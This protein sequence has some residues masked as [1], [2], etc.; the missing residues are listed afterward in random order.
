RQRAEPRGRPGPARPPAL[1]ARAGAAGAR[2][3]L[4]LGAARRRGRARVR[5]PALGLRREPA[6]RAPAARAP[7][8]PAALAPVAGGVPERRLRGRRAAGRAGGRCARVA[9]AALSRR[10]GSP[11][12][13]TPLALYLALFLLFPSLHALGL[14]FRD[15]ASGA[16]PSLASFRVLARD[17]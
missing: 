10:A 7:R 1:A 14:A 16:F 3:R 5:C 13:A 6:V 2:A 15:P 9:G 11:W 12:L 17:A 8:L 4:V